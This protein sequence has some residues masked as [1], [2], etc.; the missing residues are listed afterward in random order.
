MSLL[1]LRV[2]VI[3]LYM[4]KSME[5]FVPTYLSAFYVFLCISKYLSIICFITYLFVRLMLPNRLFSYSL[6]F[7]VWP[8]TLE[9][10]GSISQFLSSQARAIY[11]A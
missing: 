8:L 11:P 5:A 10:S 6:C 4:L 3:Y 7:R 2:E 1:T 9:T